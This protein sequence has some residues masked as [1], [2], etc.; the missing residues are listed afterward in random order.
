MSSRM[1]AVENPASGRCRRGAHCAQAGVRAGVDDPVAAAQRPAVRRVEHGDRARP[2]FSPASRRRSRSSALRRSGSRRGSRS[3]RVTRPCRRRACRS[4]SCSGSCGTFGARRSATTGGDRRP[5]G[6]RGRERIVQTRQASRRS[7]RRSALPAAAAA[8]TDR[9]AGCSSAARS[10]AE[11]SQLARRQDRASASTARRRASPCCRRGRLQEL[12]NL[13]REHDDEHDTEAG[14]D[15]FCRRCFAALPLR[16]RAFCRFSP[17]T[18][19][20]RG[21]GRSRGGRSSSARPLRR[22]SARRRTR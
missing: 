4:R 14:D 16:R 1:Y 9:A 12:R 15:V 17:P 11:A 3:S 19:D 7:E 8:K 22:P 18:D 10:A 20:I 13:V 5:R 21:R 2:A 6:R